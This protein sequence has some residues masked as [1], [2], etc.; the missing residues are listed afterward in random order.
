M[1]AH[2]SGPAFERRVTARGSWG[3]RLVALVAPSSPPSDTSLKDINTWIERHLDEFVFPGTA[4]ATALPSSAKTSS[5]TSSGTKHLNVHFHGT[6][7]LPVVNLLDRIPT[8]TRMFSVQPHYFHSLTR[9]DLTFFRHVHNP[10]NR[11]KFAIVH[12]FED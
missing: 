3:I 1:K 11:N 5:A 4:A 10:P 9:V 6:G 8:D 2:E 7:T 12:N